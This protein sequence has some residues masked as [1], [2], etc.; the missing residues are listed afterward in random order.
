MFEQERSNPM[1]YGSYGCYLGGILFLDFE[2]G[3]SWSMGFWFPLTKNLIF[4]FIF[5]WE[6]RKVYFPRYHL[7]HLL[8]GTPFFFHKYVLKFSF[9]PSGI[10][11]TKEEH[12][13]FLA[14]LESLGKGDWRGIS[15][16]FVLSR[17]P[18]Q[19]A[20]HGQKNFLRQFTSNRKKRR[21][22]LFDVTIQRPIISSSLHYNVLL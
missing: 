5:M 22:N 4:F 18:T 20:S 14:G 21:S 10:P 8:G 6:P 9:L 12:K 7:P 2:R 16:N 15:R 3:E 19:V 1:G 17:T 11:W 13:T